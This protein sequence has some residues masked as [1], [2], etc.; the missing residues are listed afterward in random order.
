[1]LKEFDILV[2]PVSS[3]FMECQVFTLATYRKTFEFRGP[4]YTAANLR[5][6]GILKLILKFLCHEKKIKHIQ[7]LFWRF[8]IFKIQV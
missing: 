6:V 5:C 7:K 4:I 1:M 8:F 2:E 3:E